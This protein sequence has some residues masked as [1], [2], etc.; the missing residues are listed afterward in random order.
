MTVLKISN[1]IVNLQENPGDQD[2]IGR[3]DSQMLMGEYFDVERYSDKI[4]N[5]LSTWAYGR[6][7]LD[8]YTGWMKD[9][10]LLY[11]R[12]T[13]THAVTTLMLHGYKSPDFKTKPEVLFSFMSRLT[14]DPDKQKDGFVGLKNSNLWVHSSSLLPL[15][16][17]VKKPADIVKT[18]LMF[19]GCPYL[20][21][22]RAATGI[23]C[24]GLVQLALQRNGI[25]CP[26]DTDQQMPVIGHPV[27]TRDIQ[28][29]DIVYFPG[30]VGIMVSKS[31]IFNASA[32]HMQ[33]V[34]EPLSVLKDAYKSAGQ[35]AI[36]GVR[37]LTP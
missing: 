24:S 6:S 35:P 26:R 13:P 23:D 5:S 17:L 21:G 19:T 11:P 9:T 20:Y 28:R 2:M 31:S 1:N 37:R 36:T 29:G 4:P 22:G 10:N 7:V 33:A 32:R 34:I 8:G 30:H 27:S 16:E 12:N 14:I 3:R 25:E 18:A 15:D